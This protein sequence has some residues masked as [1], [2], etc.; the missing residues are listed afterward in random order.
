MMTP[1][2]AVTRDV[3]DC[4]WEGGWRGR[5]EA[6]LRYAR[7]ASDASAGIPESV[8]TARDAGAARRVRTAKP[9]QAGRRLSP[10]GRRLH[11]CPVSP[12]SPAAALGPL[13]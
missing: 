9:R 11:L 4:V 3:G 6:A 8:Q 10:A 7:S 13:A 2:A 5:F 12:R 1:R